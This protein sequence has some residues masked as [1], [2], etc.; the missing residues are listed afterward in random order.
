MDD[1]ELPLADGPTLKSV[2]LTDETPTRHV[3]RIVSSA[4]VTLG[5][6]A[7][8]AGGDAFLTERLQPRRTAAPDGQRLVSDSLTTSR[9]IRRERTCSAESRTSTTTRG[10]RRRDVCQAGQRAVHLGHAPDVLA[11]HIPQHPSSRRNS[12]IA[13]RLVDS[14]AA[15]AERAVCSSPASSATRA[16]LDWTATVLSP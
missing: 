9:S 1:V 3:Y 16:A 14:T 4:G 6:F 13:A 12:R 8:L 7:T 15:N 2:L 5:E 10:F 11:G